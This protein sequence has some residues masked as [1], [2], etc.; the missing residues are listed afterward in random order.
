VTASGQT[1][2]EFV[3]T[4]AENG[5]EVRIQGRACRTPDGQWDIAETTRTAL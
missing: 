5:K 2:R 1:C 4:R 3:A